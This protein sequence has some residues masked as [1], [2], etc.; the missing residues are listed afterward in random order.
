MNRNI[1]VLFLL[2]GIFISH[3]SMAATLHTII[4]GDTN[5]DDIG[6]SVSVDVK[7][8]E[9][10]A[11]TVSN[12]TRLKLNIQKITGNRLNPRNVENAVNSISSGSDDVVF[13]Y[14]TGHG[15]NRGNSVLPTMYL[16]KPENLNI[17][18]SKIAKI[19]RGKKPRFSVVIGDTCNKP[20]NGNRRDINLS[21]RGSENYKKLFLKYKG[22]VLAGGSKVGGYSYGNGRTGGVYTTA[23]LN[24]LTIELAA[25][26]IPSWE[27]LMRTADKPIEVVPGIIQQPMSS[28]RGV[29][30]MGN[31]AVNVEDCDNIRNRPDGTCGAPPELSTGGQPNFGSSP[32]DG[33]GCTDDN[34]PDCW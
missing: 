10:L 1:N 19:I 2:I 15:Y 26:G 13:F 11:K 21:I 32:S 23:F 22:Q 7:R 33:G 27:K 20:I 5:A 25:T 12:S 18:L 30:Y 3:I 29:S 31:L 9:E 14:W 17:G 16:G 34:N 28:T 4:V 8:I 24:S 6:K